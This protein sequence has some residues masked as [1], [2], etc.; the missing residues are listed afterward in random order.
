MAELE[1]RRDAVAEELGLP[2]LIEQTRT[3]EQQ[4]ATQVESLDR[5]RTE[6]ERLES[7][8]TGLEDTR[9]KYYR[10]AIAVF[11]DLLQQNATDELKR[12]AESTAEITDDQIVARLAGVDAQ[13]EDLDQAAKQRRREIDQQQKYM[14][15]M[16]F[17]V[18]RFRAARFDSPRSL[19]ADHLNIAEEID[20][21]AHAEDLP[22]V[23]DRIRRAHRWGPTAMEQVGHVISHP[24][25]QV[26]ISAMAN[27]AAAAL[28]SHARRAGQRH[29][30]RKQG[31][32]GNASKDTWS[33]D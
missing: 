12:H 11:R 2:Q 3:A 32:R 9:G 8:L 17:L 31:G 21:A 1:R 23:W 10:E 14:D 28:Q 24:M 25:T 18:Q 33:L 13:Y 7:E 15:Q 27:A 26:L 22:S 20:R 4:R 5:L 16:G 29:A 6:T 30:D 19:F